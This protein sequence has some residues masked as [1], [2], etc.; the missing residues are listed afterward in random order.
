M[1]TEWDRIQ[2]EIDRLQNQIDALRER[3]SALACNPGRSAEGAASEAPTGPTLADVITRLSQLE[4]LIRAAAA[5]PVQKLAY[6]AEEL[7]AAIGLSS[8]TIWRLESRGLI[9][10]VPGIGKKLYSRA[11]VEAW[12]NGQA[13]GQSVAKIGSRRRNHI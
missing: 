7:R 13:S 12:V 9:R 10:S 11:T 1:N 6:T 2:R 8:V 5:G 4:D 3:A